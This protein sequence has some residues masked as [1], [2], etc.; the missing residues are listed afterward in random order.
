MGNATIL[1]TE[2]LINPVKYFRIEDSFDIRGRWH[3]DEPRAA[4]GIEL[5]SR[6]F[7][8]CSKYS[9]SGA[10]SVPAEKGSVPLDF[11][12]GPFGMPVV[13][14]CVAEMIERCAPGE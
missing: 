12:F 7:T 5:D 11:T 8:E 10:L 3:L 9:G 6:L 14:K 1:R 2:A 13:K 4:D